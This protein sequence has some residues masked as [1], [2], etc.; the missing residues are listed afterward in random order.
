MRKKLL[1]VIP[2]LGLGGAQRAFHD[3]SVELSKY[4]DVTEAVFDLDLDNLYP[5]GN[6]LESLKVEGGGGPVRKV[7]NFFKRVSQLKQ[8]KQRLKTDICISHLEGADYVNLLSKGQEKVILLIQGSKTHDRNISGATGWLR[9]S[10]LMPMLYK[11]ADRIVCVSRDIIPE[12]VDDYGVDRRKLSAINNSFEVESVWE[13][14]QEPLPP[15]M[16]AVYDSAPILVT[17]GRLAIQKNQKPLLDIFAEL[18]KT[19]PSKLVFIGDGELRTE[20]VDH[21]RSLG[22]RVYE[23]W[24]EQ[25]LTPE[26]DVYFVGLQ[27]NPFQYIRPATAFVF[28]SAWEGFPLALGEAMTCGVPVVSTDCPTGPREMLA[29]DSATPAQP[30]RAA[31]W[32]EYG[33]LMPMLTDAGTLAAD[34]QVW[35]DTLRALLQDEAKRKHLG[36][37]ARQRSNDFTH[38]NTFRRWQKLIDE[39]LAEK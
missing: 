5:S 31:E 38:A 37:V 14:A 28:P 21:A 30:I 26:F 10:V 24:A 16:Q 13:K 34:E 20:I 39:V 15:A 1:M 33:I 27:H 29:P 6:P 8:L 35:T 4:Y 17:S 9:K 7:T 22:L 23:A 36:A 25:A 2:N 3:H 32:A 11:R 19:N 12:M 18:R